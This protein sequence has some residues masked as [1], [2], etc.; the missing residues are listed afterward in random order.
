MPQGKTGQIKITTVTL[1]K[2]SYA[3]YWAGMTFHRGIPVPASPL[4]ERY[5]IRMQGETDAFY[6]LRGE[7][8]IDHQFCTDYEEFTL[9]NQAASA[10][11]DFVSSANHS[12][13]FYA[14]APSTATAAVKLNV[15]E[16]A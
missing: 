14:V 13:M 3:G 6:L 7:G 10:L 1:P 9:N 11:L 5:K 2:G 12:R 4:A 15:I 8:E 16:E